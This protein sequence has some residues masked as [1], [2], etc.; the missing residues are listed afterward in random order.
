MIEDV[1]RALERIPIWKRI[2]SLPDEV[3]RLKARVA[4][5]EAQLAGGAR[6]ACP[7]CLA[8]T[9]E[10]VSSTTDPMFGRLGV[11]ADTYRC[12]ACQHSEIRQRDT[13]KS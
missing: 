1:M 12:S 11:M 10:C 6:N 9:F 2:S 8:R 7:V 4:E 13:M 5:L 3:E